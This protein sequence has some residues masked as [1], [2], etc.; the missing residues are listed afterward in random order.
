MHADAGQPSRREQILQA[1][2][3]LFADRGFHGVGVD[4][5]GAAVG[6]Q[7]ARRSTGTSRART[8]CSPRCW[9]GIS[10]RLLAG[11]RAR[12]G[13][14]GDATRAALLDALIALPHRL[15]ARQPDA[16]HRARPRPANLPDADRTPVRRLQRPY[17]ELWVDALRRAAPG[18]DAEAAPGRARTPSSA[19]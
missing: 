15:R 5:I 9:C 8:P 16:H 7:R 3:R 13:R 1:A 6:D 12:V 14:A 2:A 18:A 11:G 4:D 10:E 17:V 19:C